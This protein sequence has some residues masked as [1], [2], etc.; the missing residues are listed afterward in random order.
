VAQKKLQITD[1][2]AE[3]GPAV[4]RLQLFQQYSAGHGVN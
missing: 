1:S 4:A 3:F 2:G